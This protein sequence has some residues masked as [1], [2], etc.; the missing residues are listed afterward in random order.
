VRDATGA[1]VITQTI[2]L[3]PAASQIAIKQLGVNGAGSSTRT[4]LTHLRIPHR[5]QT[6]SRSLHSPDPA[7]L[8]YSSG[9]WLVPEEGCQYPDRYDPHLPAA[10]GSCHLAEFG[11]NTAICRYGHR[12]DTSDFQPGG[13]MEGKEVRFGITGS[14]LFSVVTTSASCGAVNSMHDSFTPLGVLSSSS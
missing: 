9:G 7:A 13:N 12:P 8:C 14:A 11:S 1:L 5:L 2:P 6:S 10:H 4:R 3:G